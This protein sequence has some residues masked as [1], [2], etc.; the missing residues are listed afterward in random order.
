M[1]NSNKA[2]KTSAPRKDPSADDDGDR[3][4]SPRKRKRILARVAGNVAAG[5]VQSPSESSGSADAIA[6]ISVDIAE[7]ILQKIGI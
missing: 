3:P 1:T 5:I 7:A 2:K 6:E 4:L